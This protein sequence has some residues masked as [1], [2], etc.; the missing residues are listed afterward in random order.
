MTTFAQKGFIWMSLLSL[1]I[2]S[3]SC[4]V[5][6]RTVSP[7]EELTY[8]ETYT[9]ADKKKIVKALVESL[10]TK[11]PLA[12]ATDRPIIIVYGI[13]NRTSEHISTSGISDEI[14]KEILATGKARFV[15]KEQRENIISET[16]YQQSGRVT[17]ETKIRLARQLGAKY[18]LTGTLRSIEKEEGTQVRLK[19][20]SYIY[21]SLNLELTDLE[22]SLIEWADSVELVREAAKPFIGW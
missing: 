20:R 11:P 10:T 3:T 7:D 14:R 17:N 13:A 6:T 18:M 19:K 22:T 8:D 21:Y 4:T 5:S 2:F 16:D 15:N 12:S 1:F 9:F